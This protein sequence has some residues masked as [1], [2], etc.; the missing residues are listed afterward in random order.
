VLFS[1]PFLRRP[2]RTP[3]CALALACIAFLVAT[4]FISWNSLKPFL[5]DLDHVEVGMSPAEVEAIMGNYIHGTGWPNPAT[6]GELV[7]RGAVVYR[8]SNNSDWGIV[9]F[10]DG[11]VVKVEFS[12]D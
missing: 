12:A 11:R 10:R 8:H 4:Y 3:H 2:R 1:Y 5:R 7:L 6:G 9:T